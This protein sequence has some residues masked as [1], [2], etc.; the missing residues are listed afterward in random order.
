MSPEQGGEARSAA[1]P[2]Y[3]YQRLREHLRDAIARGE[4]QGKLP[5]ERVLAQRYQVNA[6]T[7]NKAL[8]DLASDGLLVRYIGRGTFVKPPGQAAPG[9][10]ASSRTFAWAGPWN[11]PA[12]TTTSLFHEAAERFRTHGYRLERVLFPRDTG[13]VVSE[14]HFPPRLL[15]R[16]AG[17]ALFDAQPSDD[18]LAVLNRR[19]I[20]LVLTSN[21]HPRVRTGAVLP[22]YAHGVF[23][24]TGHLIQ[25]GHR[26]IQ[27]IVGEDL[28]PG[29]ESA[30]GGYVAAMRRYG[31]GPRPT[32]VIRPGFDGLDILPMTQGPTALLCVGGRVARDAIQHLQRH[33]LNVPEQI[34]VATLTESSAP[35]LPRPDMTLYEVSTERLV[36]WTAELLL[37]AQA[38]QRPRV[39][40]V[41]GSLRAGGTT[42]S[43]ADEDDPD[44]INKVPSEILI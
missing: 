19:H 10:T 2:N 17:L 26:R 14:T 23:E 27:L 18:L 29:A 25:L 42:A 33:G 24:L 32:L 4:L 34:S 38:G 16:I 28:L 6:K 31:L 21:R 43:P 11:G 20:P 5:G 7:I 40:I 15:R 13:P 36:H 37:D 1:V 12:G 44:T 35:G 39:A 8:S 41:P 3:K 30:E 9:V 22:D